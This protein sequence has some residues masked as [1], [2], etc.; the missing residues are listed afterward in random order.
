MF[1]K[2][3]IGNRGEI[4]CRVAATCRKLAV[5]TVAVYSDADTRAQH[6]QQC[7]EAIHLG[8]A[9]P[10]ESYLRADKL[11]QAALSTGAQ[12]VHPGYG[13]LSENADFAQACG[14]AGLVFIGPPPSA[15]RAMGLKAQAKQLMGQAGVPLVPGYH[16]ADQNAAFLRS[17]ADAM[18]YPV[19]IKA[20][21]G[22]GGKGMRTV[23][24]SQE[25]DAAL[26]A[27]QRE[28]M[29]SFGDT[30]VLI[31]RL[32]ARPRHIEIQI[33]ADT[34]GQC[35]HLFERDCSVQRR[36]QKILEE[37]PAPGMTP[38]LRAQMGR[39]AVACAQAVGYVGAGT[40][41]FITE[42]AAETPTNTATNGSLHFYFM[43]MNTRLQVEHPVTEAITGLD[44]VEWQLRIAAGEPLPLAQHQLQING[45]AIEARI[46]AENTDANFL[47]AT[48][49]LQVLRIPKAAT[50]FERNTH[51][52]SSTVRLDAGVV[53]GDVVQPFYDSLLGKLIAW[54]PD[55]AQ[56][57]ARL[58]A[59]LAQ[60]HIV[61]VH[62]NVA[63]LRRILASTSF[64]QADLDT[65]L[66]SREHAAL[67]SCAAMPAELVAAGVA[68]H[69]LAAQQ[70]LEK[71]DQQHQNWPDPWSQRN[72]WRLHG[73][74]TQRFELEFQGNSK[75]S[76]LYSLE[77]TAGAQILVCGKQR[78][79]FE[80]EATIDADMD[81]DSRTHTNAAQPGP[82]YTVVLN[83]QRSVLSVYA[84]Q[85]AEFGKA[86]GATNYSTN[87][88]AGNV[89]YSVFS[90]QTCAVVSLRGSL[91]HLTPQA[92]AAG[93]LTAPMSGK[94]IALLT[95]PGAQVNADQ[96][97]LV[98]EA[99][100]ME[101]TVTAPCAG[102]VEQVFYAV[103]DQVA[104]GAELLRLTPTPAA[105]SV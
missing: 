51:V 15:M 48:G 74:A 59:A 40:V 17:Q 96:P 14:D 46:C 38:E 97:L 42:T 2:I 37:A 30:A 77:N 50:H 25:F 80:F 49:P 93:N 9:T 11:I 103:G 33:F 19:L 28:A 65:A 104:E 101:H 22:G 57:L 68:A 105:S 86:G 70:V 60:I 6:V 13:F 35:V 7:D 29:H 5:Q 73:V 66:I 44:L 27:C 88:S 1:S 72:S 18:G 4:A 56:A 58:D 43:E 63:F 47:P 92:P 26:A 102:H 10:A 83:G 75:L 3:L 55:R 99:M 8:G 67:F 84:T 79:A 32:L 16:G 53:E 76:Q 85:P 21:A 52:N 24:N 39:A 87:G 36:H 95:L 20:S 54:G 82:R 100:K 12:A 98:M 94:V 91:T 61:G 71:A 78:W 81:T 89:L 90:P 23:L 41:E 45:H 62:T 64:V 34:H 69:V 31:E